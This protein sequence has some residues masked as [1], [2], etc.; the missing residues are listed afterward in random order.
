MYLKSE[1]KVVVELVAG[2]VIDWQR[3][4]CGRECIFGWTEGVSIYAGPRL[5]GT[6]GACG[7]TR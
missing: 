1:K 3:L 6:H 4:S 7:E 5:L 2:F